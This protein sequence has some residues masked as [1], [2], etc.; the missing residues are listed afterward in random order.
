MIG[1]LGFTE[2]A[3]ILILALLIFG[4]KRLPEMGRML[5]K[6]MGEFRR[7]SNEL[8]RTF[9][10][11]MSLAEEEKR[12]SARPQLA[13]RREPAATVSRQPSGP[14]VLAEEAPTDQGATSDPGASAGEG[15]TPSAVTEGADLELESS[16]A[17]KKKPA[18]PDG[19]SA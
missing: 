12:E 15:S 2:V 13:D 4:P 17:V 19:E 18:A 10:V 11:E 16:S 7:A 3:F 14:S 8:K 5:G 9:N 6:G 1:S